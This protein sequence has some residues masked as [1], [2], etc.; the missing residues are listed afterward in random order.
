MTPSRAANAGL[1][2]GP[3]RGDPGDVDLDHRGQLRGGVAGRT[4]CSW[5]STAGSAAAS[6]WCRSARWPPRRASARCEPAA[7]RRGRSRG[8]ARLPEPARRAAALAASAAAT[9]SSRRIRPPTPVPLTD[10]QVDAA[11]GGEL[12]DH[13]GDVGALGHL[14]RRHRLG[15]AAGA[16]AALGASAVRRLGRCR[17]GRR[18]AALAAASG[19][20]AFGASGGGLRLRARVRERRPERRSR[21]R[22]RRAGRRPRW[23][24]PR[25]R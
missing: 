9:T 24:R 19:A 4:S 10:R 25:R 20:S 17:P 3:Q 18:R 7:R 13:R 11:V 6:G 15:G 12:A 23:S 2:P 16:G 5:R 1:R 21:H 8:A 22:S 14:R